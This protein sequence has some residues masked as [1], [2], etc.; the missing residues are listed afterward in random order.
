MQ[1]WVRSLVWF[2]AT[3]PAYM[4]LI[5]REIAT[6][7]GVEPMESALG[8]PEEAFTR[9]PLRET[10]QA[11]EEMYDRGVEQGVLRPTDRRHVS[12]M[13]NGAVLSGLAWPYGGGRKDFPPTAGEL[14]RLQDDAVAIFQALTDA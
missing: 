9:G 8:P 4:I 11:F 13:L 3:R 7:G 2:Y 12:A 10:S 6:P 1:A 14:M 5:L